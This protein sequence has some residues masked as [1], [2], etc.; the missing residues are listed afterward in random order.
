MNDFDFCPKTLSRIHIGPLSCY[1]NSYLKILHDQG[2]ASKSAGLQVRL[3]ADL[4]RWLDD[5]GYSAAHVSPKLVDRYLKCRYQH[6][7]KRTEDSAALNRLIDLLRDMRVISFQPSTAID[8]P[9]QRIVD[10]FR[11][12]LRQERALSPLTIYNQT[13]FAREFLN[14]RFGSSR[15]IDL[16]RLRAQHVTGFVR[17]RAQNLS[18]KSAKVMT[19]ALRSFFRYLRYHGELNSDLAACVPGVACWPLS[20]IP[21]YLESDQVRLVLKSCDRQSANGIRDYAVLLLLARLGLRASE[22]AFLK[23]EDIDWEEGRI[24]VFGKGGFRSQLPLPA[25]VGAAIVTYLQ[26]SRPRCP[27]RFVFIRAQA[28]RREFISASTIGA[29]VRRAIAR[30]GIDSPRKG[31]HVLRHS[32]ATRMLQQGASLAEIGEILRHHDP[33]TTAIYAKVDLAAL[34]RLAPAWPGGE[35]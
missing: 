5:K 7:Q 31:A 24:T 27:S 16:A 8:T 32:L 18:S 20:E 12:Y 28:P 9:I 14:E 3:I 13:R 23:L 19:T 15:T 22:V 30:A 11:V 33:N 4:S 10:S 29:I 1:I 25:D 21:K 35:A 17:R 2:Y 6:F 34:R 26:K